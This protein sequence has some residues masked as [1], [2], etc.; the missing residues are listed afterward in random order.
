[1]KSHYSLLFPGGD[2]SF[3]T[4][5]DKTMHDLGLDLIIRQVAQTEAERNLILRILMDM[6][7]DPEITRY[8]ADI[9]EDIR[10]NPKMREEMTT[11]LDKIGFLRDYGSFRHEFDENAGVWD[12]LHRLEEIRDY[13]ACVEAIYHCL[14]DAQITSKGLTGLREHVRE[15]YHDRGF[16]ELK[17]DIAGLKASTTQLK[18]VTV[19]INLNSR[20]EAESIGLV[21]VNSKPFTKSGI[22]G[23]FV[24]HI[25]S[26]ESAV[27][28]DTV[29]ED[30]EW[31]G[32]LHY[33]PVDVSDRNLADF[34]EAV[35]KLNLAASHPL[36]MMGLSTLPEQ[37]QVTDITMY[38]DRITN[39]MLSGTVKHLKEIL[40][41]Y[42]TV[43]ITDMTDLMPEF[44]YYI[45]WAQ[46]LEKLELQGALFCKPEACGDGIR[47]ESEGFYNLK[48]AAFPSAEHEA[49]VPND[50]VFDDEN[51]VYILTGANRGG[52]TTVT[53]AIGQLFVLAQGGIYV[54]G[55]RF[56]FRPA[57]AV[58]THFPAD[59]DETMD[60]GRLGEECKRFRELFLEATGHS[61]LLLN[62]TF[63]T[64]SFEEG[65]YIARD[66]VRAMLEKGA[67]AIY[68]THMHKLAFELD[69]INGATDRGGASSLVVENDGAQRSYKIRSA[70]PE[71]RSYAGDI[72]EKYGVTYE[73]LTNM[74]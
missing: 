33:H 74:V 5:S 50:M 4:I 73:M 69:E 59:E 31:N 54:P 20:F 7:D 11:I 39:R 60:L 18:S 23:D 21:S 12:L 66:A 32:D 43:T 34:P 47:M 48:L 58:Y 40:K 13:I 17:A 63:S 37:D 30:S 62:E 8:R 71:G 52:K 16:A 2:S 24:D 67:R 45:C 61:L 56:V 22:L 41:K 25:R 3:H 29:H 15:L 51:R 26:S 68:N 10:K 36:L 1:M 65:Y 46:Y 38:M 55:T 64:T 9:F 53:Q 70:K 44:R 19:G 49:I 42:V 14:Q 28:G 35:M 72:A 57:D 27:H 6:T